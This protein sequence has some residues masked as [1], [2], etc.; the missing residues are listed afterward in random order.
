MTAK[1]LIDE[2]KFYFLSINEQNHIKK[3]RVLDRH[4][5]EMVAFTLQ[6]EWERSTADAQNNTVSLIKES[7][8]NYLASNAAHERTDIKIKEEEC[9]DDESMID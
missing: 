4:G 7:E 1:S 9:L 3:Y 5:K 2:L 8:S 6:K